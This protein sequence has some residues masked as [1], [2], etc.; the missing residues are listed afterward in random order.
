MLRHGQWPLGDPRPASRSRAWRS[1]QTESAFIVTTISSCL[2]LPTRPRGRCNPGVDLDKHTQMLT[3]SPTGTARERTPWRDSAVG[4]GSAPV[5]WIIIEEIGKKADVIGGLVIAV[6]TYFAGVIRGKRY[7]QEDLGATAA[8]EAAETSRE[9]D[10]RIDDVVQRYAN[11]VRHN[12]TGALHGL[13]VAGIKNLRSS[14]EIH[15]ARERAT[16]QTG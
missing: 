3:T 1:A 10:R 15:L 7:R 8:R 14:E 11:L 4:V 16:A 9:A 6:L 13:L 5:I 12:T 2:G